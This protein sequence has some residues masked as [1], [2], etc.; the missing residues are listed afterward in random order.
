MQ[1]KC[2]RGQHDGEIGD[3]GQGVAVGTSQPLRNLLGRGRPADGDQ[4]EGGL[5]EQGEDEGEE[6]EGHRGQRQ[7]PAPA[8]GAQHQ[9][10]QS[11]FCHCAKHPEALHAHTSYCNSHKNCKISA[12]RTPK[13]H[14]IVQYSCSLQMCLD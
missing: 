3:L 2:C 5:G 4:E 1:V 12:K 11:S 7:Q 8:Q 9:P 13:Y 10:G 14:R 6:E